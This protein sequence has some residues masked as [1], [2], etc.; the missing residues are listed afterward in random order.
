MV[1]GNISERIEKLFEICLKSWDSNMIA[2]YH[3]ELD[4]SS[5]LEGCEITNNQMLI[6]CLNWIVTWCRSGVQYETSTL[7]R[8]SACLKEGHLK[9]SL[10]VFEYL[11]AYIKARIDVDASIPEI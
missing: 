10:R 3:P 8:Y 6:G 9:A 4:S 11:K 5:L 2:D 1:N 7:T